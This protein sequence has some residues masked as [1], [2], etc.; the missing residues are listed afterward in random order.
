MSNEIPQWNESGV[1]PPISESSPTS[2]YRSPYKTTT[3]ELVNRYTLNK[4]RADILSGF[5]RFRSRLY[6]IG[7]IDGFQWIDGSFTEN[8]ELTE[9]RKPNDIDV[10]TFFDV[11]EGETQN[12]LVQKAS[13]LFLPDFADWRKD[14]FMTDAY[15][16]PLGVS[17]NLLVERTVYWYSMWAHKR[18]LSWK[19]F[20]QVPLSPQ[21]DIQAKIILDDL[22]SGGFYE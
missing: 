7:M 22:I 4:R 15:W 20:L 10:V 3:V 18:D 13:D 2:A 1:L 16:Q 12:S 9:S 8:I 6:D 14:T 21:D 5:L 17:P 19:G 11:P